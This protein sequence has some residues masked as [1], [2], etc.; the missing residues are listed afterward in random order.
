MTAQAVLF[1]D[2]VKGAFPGP[3]SSQAVG[4]GELGSA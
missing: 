3:F 4:R 1:Q 2:M